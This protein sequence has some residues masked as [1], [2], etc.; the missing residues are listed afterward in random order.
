MESA[1]HSVEGTL[2]HPA[3][4]DLGHSALCQCGG[5]TEKRIKK[6]DNCEK[7]ERQDSRRSGCILPHAH[8][9][10]MMEPVEFT[11]LLRNETKKGMDEIV[12][13]TSKVGKTVEQVTDDFKK[14]M[15]EQSEVVKQV[16]K[17]IASLE[18]QL[19]KNA[20]GKAKTELAAELTAAKKVL[21]E[22][23]GELALLEKQV[24][25]SAQKHIMLRTEIRNLKEQMATMT[26]GTQEYA[27]AMQRLGD[28]QDRMG[29]INTQGRIFS[30]DNKKIKATMDAVSGLTGVM[31][32]GVG[33]ASLFGMEEEKLAKI[34][35]KL[36]AVMA[37]TMGVQQVANTL[38]KDSYFTHVLLAKGKDMLTAANTR[39]AAA[40][41]ISNVAAQALMAT[42]TLGLSVAITAAIVLWNKYS[43]AQEKAAA[44]A[45]E[46]LEIEKDG[47]AQMIQSRA[48]LDSTIDSLKEFN[49][50]KEQEK[51]KV[52]EL[53]GK[54]GEAFGYYKS[55]S[56]WYDV[57]AQKSE[58]YIQLLFLQ[59]KAQSLVNKAVEADEQ[60]NKIEAAPESDYDFWWG[61]GG[62][63]DRFFSRSKDTTGAK[64]AKE[65]AKRDKEA[66]RDAY[67]EEAKVLQKEIAEIKKTN[68]LGGHVEP[69]K[70][71][72][73]SKTNE[74][75]RTADAELNARR[76]IEEMTIALMEEGEA[77]KKA[78]A[79]KHF[80]DEIERIGKEER[81][82]MTA[83]KEAREKGF[84]VSPGQAEAVT[85]QAKQQRRLAAELYIKDYY[86]VEKE[87]TDKSKKLKEEAQSWIDYNKEFGDYQEKR[88]AII[89]DYESKIE[90]AKTGGEKAALK[91]QEEQAVRELDKSILEK[92]DLWTRLFSDA[93]KH[94][95]AY[96][97]RT[98]AETQQ[99]LDY[100]N[101]IEG[102]KLPTDISEDYIKSLKP[103]E[104][105]AIMDALIRQRDVLNKRNPFQ[106][107]IDGFKRL[108]DAGQDVEKQFEATQHMIEGMND[109][110]S[111]AGQV[112][113]A[114]DMLGI[115]AGFA[116][117]KVSD[118]LSNTVSMAQTG[119]SIGG[120]WGAAIGGALGLASGL[121]SSLS[122]LF[123]ADYSGYE[124]MVAKYDVLLDVWDQLLDKKKA[125]IKES[126]STEAVKA[127][128]EALGLL[129]AEKEVNK[130]LA[131]SRLSAGSSA[132]SHSIGYRMWK[133]FYKWEGKNWRNVSGE[134]TRGLKDAG[135]GDVQF[136]DMNSML[137]M[138]SKQLEWIKTNYSGLWS[139][140]DGDFRQYLDNIIQYGE[141]EKEIIESVK[142]QITGISLSEFES[143]YLSMISDLNSTNEDFADNL[144]KYL[145]TS[146]FRSLIAEKYKGQI[147]S[148]YDS[149]YDYGKDGIDTDEA[150]KLRKRQRELT[151]AM[152]ADREKLTKAFGWSADGSSS[153]Q[154]GR[155]GAVTTI[156]EETGGKIEGIL[157]VMT[158]HLIGMDDNIKDISKNSYESIGLLSKIAE[159]T[160]CLPAM[161]E[162]LERMDTN[163][164][165]VKLI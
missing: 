119:A 64:R 14:K 70:N 101:K 51:A 158:D 109:V 44:K 156:T 11:M 97:E 23:K 58:T 29:D 152:L 43:D 128:E 68:G 57:L 52:K 121:A 138:T 99:L 45:K 92:S 85:D 7:E 159:N 114:M 55:V 103:D 38:N 161:A 50:S 110:S 116:L 6:N 137:K 19:K 18:K 132:G 153:S 34:Q 16:E 17:D 91:K 47:R 106:H 107:L 12:R 160:A 33:A 65:M 163:G 21:A 86:A 59:A 165:R 54:Y 84:K 35:T 79:R 26:E 108:K 2:H 49:G 61:A 77:K 78:L 117:K 131:E 13:D 62:K 113:D 88:A 164:T 155:A 120:P 98:I 69:D 145:R 1:L 135:L 94:T 140:M 15:K 42:L 30:D 63:V 31:T 66:I 151:D 8:T 72:P 83:L 123:G 48:E 126:Y 146:I 144:E 40:L 24:E 112:G 134:V 147:Q 74:A 46:R 27:A 122:G 80:D 118:M 89:A 4:D 39:L 148:L 25:Q 129:D 37:I 130:R 115:K 36:Q 60:V 10:A 53:N 73:G 141:V 56:E 136:N 100:I 143:S 162:V 90:K 75:D 102:A 9:R 93:E 32:A 28:L 142:E 139:V 127:G 5:R 96:I 111:I 149:F 154:S 67:L 95:S 22:E 82:R 105:K 3:A 87:Y 76:K 124:K 157:N 150:E 41:G 71:T 104:L 125:Y 81:E 133:G 20:P